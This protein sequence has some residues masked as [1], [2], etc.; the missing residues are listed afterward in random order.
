MPA[1]AVGMDEGQSCSKGEGKEEERKEEEEN[2]ESG[3]LGDR[4][5]VH[6]PSSGEEEPLAWRGVRHVGCEVAIGS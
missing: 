2:V 5:E 1:E 3:V 4:A 6:A